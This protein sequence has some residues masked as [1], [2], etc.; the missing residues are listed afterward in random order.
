VHGRTAVDLGSGTGIFSR[1]L[2]SRGWEV[3]GVEPNAAMRGAAERDGGARYVDG[4]AEATG[5]PAQSAAL[6]IGA[7]AFHWFRLPEALAEI[8]R[9]G[10]ERAVA[11][12]NVHRDS[13]FAEAYRQVLLAFSTDYPTVP[14]PEPTLAALQ[15][16]RPGGDVAVF[17]HEQSLDESGMLGRA[18]SSSYVV[19]G[20]ADRVGF[21]DALAQAFREHARDGRV[22]LQYETRLYSWS[23]GRGS[24]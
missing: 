13:G 16:L 15:D 2:A 5:L 22:S 4:A 6:V 12:W 17:P 24:R 3:V 21:D 10:V 14:R 7:Q 1:L 18:W 19:H 11:V 9:I 23:L 8:D 20:V